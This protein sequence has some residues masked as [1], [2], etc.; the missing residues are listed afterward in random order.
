MRVA[1]IHLLFSFN[2]SQNR[3][4]WL[5]WWER[6]R[7]L[8]YLG[9]WRQ[10]NLPPDATSLNRDIFI[11][12]CIAGGGLPVML[13]SKMREPASWG[14]FKAIL[15]NCGSVINKAMWLWT[16]STFC[17]GCVSRLWAPSIMQPN[18]SC[19]NLAQSVRAASHSLL[20]SA[21][22]KT[23]SYYC[24]LT[25]VGNMPFFTPE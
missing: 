4:R 22:Q 23:C 3:C 25:E 15:L 13:G 18:L 9:Q 11:F 10:Q 16:C 21:R 12:I 14:G 19:S 6:A 7:L 5:I 24:V 1:C 20:Y 17:W 8:Q 2:S